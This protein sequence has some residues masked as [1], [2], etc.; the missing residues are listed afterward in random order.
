[1]SSVRYVVDVIRASSTTASTTT[2]CERCKFYRAEPGL[3]LQGVIAHPST[4][5][6][7]SSKPVLGPCPIENYVPRSIC[8]EH[9]PDCGC[10]GPV[11]TRGMVGWAGGGSGPDFFINTFAKPV[12]WWENQHTVWGEIRDEES[13]RVVESAYDLPA[14]VS[15]MR[16]LDEEI[17]FTLELVQ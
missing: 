1:M 15:G 6:T 3:L 12:D 4:T 9:D 5:T 14:H 7:S 13:L 16:M 11:M 10:H 17:E 8:P 2:K